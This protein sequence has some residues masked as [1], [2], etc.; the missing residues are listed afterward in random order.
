MFYCPEMVSKF[1]LMLTVDFFLGYGIFVDEDI[2]HGDF[3]VDYYGKLITE[4]DADQ[5]LDLTYIYYFELT[6]KT[7]ALVSIE[8]LVYYEDFK[9]A[10]LLCLLSNFLFV[11]F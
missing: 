5:I 6:G 7:Y 2:A 3:I 10:D 9:M 11:F 4:E 1:L 8:M